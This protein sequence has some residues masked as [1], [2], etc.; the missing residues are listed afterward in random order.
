VT[1]PEP[2]TSGQDAVSDE[3]ATPWCLGCES[4]PEGE[5]VLVDS[6][7]E[8]SAC[9][10]SIV[11]VSALVATVAEQMP[12]YVT[13]DDLELMGEVLPAAA[14]HIRADERARILA[15]LDDHARYHAWHAELEHR[16]HPEAAASVLDGV[17]AY[18]VDVVGGTEGESRG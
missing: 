12:G 11:R 5:V 6:W 15:A 17:R 16:R 7:E 4:I 14:P 9:G 18:L 1:S 2:E 8:H 10:G 3:A 13:A